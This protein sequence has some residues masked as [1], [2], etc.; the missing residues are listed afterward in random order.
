MYT[1]VQ[2]NPVKYGT[3]VLPWWRHQ[4]ET[5]S[6]LLAICAGNSP[7][8]GEFPAQRPVTR[9]F[10]VFFDLRLNKRLRKPSCGWWFDTLSR[11]L[12]RH[13]NDVFK[14]INNP[15]SYRCSFISDMSV[16]VY[17][18]RGTSTICSTVC[19]GYQER[20]HQRSASLAFS[21]HTGKGQV[22][23]C[24]HGMISSC[25][26]EI[27]GV[28]IIHSGQMN[29]ACHLSMG[30]TITAHRRGLRFTGKYTAFRIR[31]VLSEEVLY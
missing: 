12:W 21:F 27:H 2:S 8:P 5:F 7:V 31:T 9:S 19:S 29:R 25:L 22:V 23:R 30:L 26:Y 16:I 4:M 15:V 18:I 24:F 10:D 28:A 17:Q 6:A 3:C 11:P 13:R 1:S 20:K 14:Y